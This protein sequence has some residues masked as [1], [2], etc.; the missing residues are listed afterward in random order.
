MRT[1]VVNENLSW[2]YAPN[3]EFYSENQE[4][5]QILLRISEEK[6]VGWGLWRRLQQPSVEKAE[7]NLGAASGDHDVIMIEATNEPLAGGNSAETRENVKSTKTRKE[8][9][10]E[11][12]RD[13]GADI[14]FD[15]ITVG[16]LGCK[17]K[18]INDEVK[19]GEKPN[20]IIGLATT[21]KAAKGSI[22]PQ[23]EDQMKNIGTKTNWAE[24]FGSSGVAISKVP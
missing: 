10:E 1:F 21:V 22:A 19:T 15:G 3:S 7:G 20:V 4:L 24:V 18:K 16:P 9:S 6:I 13:H 8:H 11:G 17:A 5:T 2:F 12:G 23:E 14:L